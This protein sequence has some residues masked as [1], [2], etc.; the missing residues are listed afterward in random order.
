M[1]LSTWSCTS[2][3]MP[4]HIMQTSIQ[5]QTQQLLLS[6]H[7][8]WLAT[9][10]YPLTHTH[11]HNAHTANIS[12]CFCCWL[13]LHLSPANFIY[14][15]EQ[16]ASPQLLFMFIRARVDRRQSLCFAVVPNQLKQ[17]TS[18]YSREFV[19]IFFFVCFFL[20]SRVAAIVPLLRI[21]NNCTTSQ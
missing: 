14:K 18:V 7:M 10:L 12:V 20:L 15:H 5:S 21:R 6:H 19:Y 16:T 3:S 1:V 17:A 13:F 9:S 11:T 4:Q 8:R 2:P